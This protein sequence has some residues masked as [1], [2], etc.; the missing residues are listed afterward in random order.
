MDKP[1][2]SW[3]K[4]LTYLL[5]GLINIQPVL[6][7]VVVG[8]TNTTTITAGN[9]VEVVN[10]AA[11]NSKGLSHNQYQQFNVDKSGLILNNS[12]AQLSQSQ[13]G[14]LL[15]N[16]PNLTGQAAS[17]ILNEVT[18]ANRSQLQG[19]TEVFGASA[20]V[21]LANP[22][23]ITCDGCGFINTPR[24]TLS[25]GTP[26]LAN[27]DVS[28][29]DVS[30]G[31][32][33]IEGLGL[34]ASQ[35]T[36]FDIISR[37]AQINAEIHAQNLTIVTGQNHVDYETN[38]A[39]KKATSTSPLPALAIDS[40]SLGGMYAGRIALIAT[41]EGVGVNVGNLAASQEGIHITADGKIVM[42]NTS[43]AQSLTVSTSD[44][45]EMNGNHSAGKQMSLTG[46]AISASNGTLVAGSEMALT[47]GS[48][49]LIHSA[50]EAAQFTA[51][52]DKVSIDET[53][54]VTS[55][56]AS[57]TQ[58]GTLDN[59]GAV[60]VSGDMAIA[61]DT[62]SLTG[63]GNIKAAT[64]TVDVQ[65]LSFETNAEV[66]D[67][68]LTARHALALTAGAQLSASNNISLSGENINQSG[69]LTA[70]Q[71]IA[72]NA[73][74]TLTHNGTTQGKDVSITAQTL[75]QTG[76]LTGN[77]SVVINS[78]AVVLDGDTTAGQRLVVNA[79]TLT[80]RGKVQSG[81]TVT[82][83][84]DTS[85]NT[86]AGSALL[87]GGD[88]KL[89]GS[90]VELAGTTQSAGS[91]IIDAQSSVLDGAISAKKAVTISGKTLTQSGVLVSGDSLTL[92][93]TESITLD[94]TVEAATDITATTQ[95]FS[96]SLTLVSGG[97]I[98]V[99][100]NDTTIEG[101]TSSGGDLTITS[102]TLNQ[103]G[104]TLAQSDMTLITDNS[105]L[106]GSVESKKTLAI[107]ANNRLTTASGTKLTSGDAITINAGTF[108]HQ[109]HLTSQ[110]NTQLTTQ[111]LTNQGELTSNQNLSLAT[112]TLN[113]QGKLSANG[114]M[115]LT[116][117]GAL[118]MSKNLSSGGDL[119]ITAHS[120]NNRA[121]INSAKHTKVTLTGGLTNQSRG[122]I[123]GDTTQIIANSIS[124]SGTLQALNLLSIATAS[125]TNPGALIALGDLIATVSGTATNTDT[126]LIYAGNNGAIYANALNNYGE[127]LTQNNLTI[128]RNAA[129]Q[130]SNSLLNSSASIESLAGDISIYA[131]TV[132]NKVTTLITNPTSNLDI[133]SSFS[134][135]FE[136]NNTSYEPEYKQ[137]S[138]VVETRGGDSR[139]HVYYSTLESSDHFTVKV[140]EEGATIKRGSANTRLNAGKRLFINAVNVINDASLMSGSSILI[141]ALSLNNISYALD[142]YTTYYDYELPA[143]ENNYRRG[144][145]RGTIFNRVGSRRVKTGVSGTLDSSITATGNILLNVVNE[146]DN[147]TI[148]RY[149]SR[150]TPL[151]SSKST[152]TTQSADVTGPNSV[153]LVD[154]SSID[155]LNITLSRFNDVPFPEFRLPSSPNGLF[156]YSK[157]PASGY[158]IETNPLLTNLG[159]YLGSDYFLGN[160]GFDPEKEITFLGDAF[161]DTRVV[162]QAIFEQTGKRYLNESVGNDFGQMQQLMDAAASQKSGLNLE[163][164][165]ALSPEQVANLSQDILWYE[166]IEVNGQTV[167]APKLYLAQLT[168]D[169]IS[170]G[171]VI[172]GRDIDIKAGEINNSGAM[173]ADNT[174]SLKSDSSIH[175]DTG[176]LSGGGDVALVA[177]G[178][179]ENVSGVITGDNVSLDSTNGSVINR[180]LVQINEYNQND[181]TTDMGQTSEIA[182]TG[183]LSINAGKNILN[184]G[185]RLSAKGDTSLT[186]GEDIRFS[187]IE[188]K[189][190]KQQYVNWSTV[191]TLEVKHQG[192]QLISQG[193]ISL[194][195][196]K[197]I[198]LTSAT[199]SAKSDLDVS[200]GGDI[201]IDTALNENYQRTDKRGYTDINR[202][203]THQGSTLSGNNVALTSNKNI[204]L[205]GSS[206]EAKQ[207][208]GVSA[209]GDVSIVAVNDS[210]YH[211]TKT[212]KKKSFGRSKTIIH[213][214]LNETVKG[215]AI[216]AGE[217]ISITAQALGAIQTAGGD[218]DIQV[219]GSSLNADGNVALNADG[220]IVLAAQQYKEYERN[221]TIKK[222]FG[223]LS[224]QDKG[225]IDDATLLNSS[226]ALSGRDININAGRDIAALASE[227]VADGNVNL[228][229]I[230]EVL[231]SAGEVLKQSQ[232]WN[233]KTSFLSGG[234]LF[235]MESQR[236]GLE[237]KT[238]QSSVVQSGGDLT[239]DAGNIKVVG[240]D[241]ASGNNATLL[242]DT[243]DIEFLAATETQKS[244]EKNEK[245]SI[246][247]DGITKMLTSNPSDIVKIEDG[248]IKISMEK[249]QYDKVD[250]DRRATKKKGSE[251]MA[252]RGITAD[253]QAD[254]FIE[255]S[256]LL[257]GQNSEGEGDIRLTA[258]DNIII[259]EAKESSSSKTEEVHAKAE[260]S[261]VVQHQAVEVAKA[262]KGL[263]ESTENLKQAKKDYSTYKKQ[264]DSL[265][266]S[267]A[268]L[269]QEY[270]DKEPGVQFADVE[271]FRDLV[272]DV[273]SDDSWY[274]AGIVLAVED[275]ASKTLLVYQQVA[276]GVAS[277]SAFGWGFNAGLELDLVASK[278][279]SQTQA[280]GSLASKLSGQNITLDAGN[281]QGNQVLVQG[282]QLDAKETLTIDANEVNLLA[283]TETQSNKSSNDTVSGTVSVTF[284]GATGGANVN[285]GYSKNR[286]GS[287]ATTHTNSQ[288]AGKN[289][290]ISSTENTNI[291]GANVEATENLTLTVGQDLNVASVQDRFK[292]DSKSMG[293][294][295][296][297]SLSAV[298][299][300]KNGV[301]KG[302]SGEE[303]G[304]LTGV[305][306]GM[307][308][309]SNRTSSKQTVLTTLTSGNNA[310]ITV[311]NNTDIKG[312]LVATVDKEGK[313]L[314]NLNLST[315]TFSYADLTNTDYS[316]NRSAGLNTGVAVNGDSDKGADGKGPV[317]IGELEQSK[318]M[319]DAT[320]NSTSLQYVNASGYNK[321]KTLA[322]VGQG[323]VTITDSENSHDTTA[324]N[325]D[326]EHTEKDLFTVDRK[327]GDFDV[328]VDHR[329][330]SEDGHKAIAKDIETTHEAGED[331]YRA[332]DS[333]VSS[334]DMDLFDFGKSVSDNRKLTELKNDLLSSQEGLDLLKDLKSTEADKV[335]AAQAEISKKAQ[336]K[337]GLTPEQVNFYD[338]DKTTSVAMQDN[339][340]R[341]VHGG[342]VTDDDHE[343][344]GEVNVDVSD[345]TTKTE[346]LNTL[347]HETYESITE[348]TTGEQTAAQEDLAKS[349]GN[350]LEDRVNQAAGGDLDKTVDK[351]WN[352]SLV[353]SSTAQLGTERVN[354]VGDANVDY[355][356]TQTEA[357]RREELRSFIESCKDASCRN[358]SEFKSK[359]EELGSI[360]KKDDQRD[361][362]FKK[363][364]YSGGGDECNSESAKVVAAHDTWDK[365]T[366]VK[367]SA[368]SSEFTTLESQ[369]A[370]AKSQP[371]E[372]AAGSALA[373]MPTDILIGAIS[374]VPEMVDLATTASAAIQGD[375]GAQ[376]QLKAMYESA[377]ET[378]SDPN[379]AADK[380][381]ADIQA[382]EANGEISPHEAKKQISK[383]YISVAA[384]ATGSAYGIAKIGGSS[385]K[386]E[387]AY[388][389]TNGS[390]IAQNII[391]G[392]NP[393]FLNPDSR[394]GKA[395]YIGDTAQ[396]VMSELAHYGADTTHAIRYTI[397]LNKAKVLD[398]TNPNVASKWG[399]SGGPIN[400]KTKSLGD[401]AIEKGFDVIKFN[402][403]RSGGVNHAVLDNF[404]NV[405]KP[406]LVVPTNP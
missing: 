248:K 262:I 271:E 228:T 176:T 6:A 250:T 38:V 226:Y 370:N 87:S 203:L 127:I 73:S 121:E 63:A 172:A 287:D 178:D 318:P 126:G 40:S 162:T 157:G 202:L 296:G 290:I 163:L 47:A 206:I 242:A 58:L 329:L 395:F 194:K 42:G 399:Y 214:S 394:F 134:G 286:D 187:T 34:D 125:L 404:N 113:H 111:S 153:R 166:Q 244:Y 281:A 20:N 282:A 90:I 62:L 402:S 46:E 401:L 396:T 388:H 100:A 339:D 171:A 223:G 49:E 18:G 124:N 253:S 78:D 143:K 251:L 333:Y 322:T 212:K 123:S 117:N 155:Q 314:G 376:Q 120:L 174:L 367:D 266:K 138:E 327:Q 57:L 95:D 25:T 133:T 216:T 372:L 190:H 81:D 406:E 99:T 64:L 328:T 151:G 13:L 256:Q 227:V 128:A 22:Y 313:D 149:A 331:I 29:F 28:G 17:V 145:Y 210:N 106:T 365:D 175:N 345:A 274:Q 80:I 305:N 79:D 4:T 277:A 393:D 188:N 31:S 179:I 302:Y 129:N 45:I 311:A 109:G 307:H 308:T 276:A 102:A 27:G 93:Q 159:N 169:N 54:R 352:S 374:A 1:I 264:L 292:S 222:G 198:A 211:Y 342:V 140:K 312:A 23:G 5:C 371:W 284:F 239:I 289:I 357:Q 101:V 332:A 364:C 180:T 141:N 347:G 377:V 337:Y 221:Q 317:P 325:R 201:T 92:T 249:A 321:S 2:S 39:T 303:A 14:G 300:G 215:S 137:R 299:S 220:D 383:F 285:L 254:I 72:L 77:Q 61:G 52:A 268:L 229:A 56:S 114:D 375:E 241:I 381:I 83:S 247:F 82:L 349:F 107:T 319:V 351:N 359:Q 283:S 158:L 44:N 131:D 278:S 362:D 293:V 96:S 156:I 199:V 191:D 323:T 231:I 217:D 294:N 258:K 298:D 257:A 366:A 397:N 259:K 8:G 51:Q 66:Q 55:Q 288:L 118:V 379:G 309:S 74:K 108:T 269:E 21:I 12:T 189:T 3:R 245:L 237:T 353:N 230:D 7:N 150:V 97:D 119:S 213:E 144:S 164:G 360:I 19:Y 148:K 142:A 391:D 385:K 348:N 232:E 24:V 291:V 88:M 154:V 105:N 173:L 208:V 389:A 192:S 37:T 130:K 207:S 252:K 392:I 30:E 279:E 193:K 112:D 86:M 160:V 301:L 403:E 358:T 304:K 273:K 89:D 267:L 98:T 33:T 177:K 68:T 234:N 69:T 53:S 346:L 405:L 59:Q 115:A 197:D 400:D 182:A 382:K 260:A 186:A 26:E 48:V 32:V 335:L 315:N 340:V 235:E 116:V 386:I 91:L 103:S 330:L 398:L 35:Q 67:A 355:Y 219:V 378:M 94:G 387:N 390:H 344:H 306:A 240:S 16:N 9:G 195:A 41:E 84:G 275:V 243:G 15:Q 50:A 11:P 270:V 297:F 261:I 85:L 10:I 205:S 350:Q 75:N 218:S 369:N 135:S 196:G 36:Y 380:Y 238:A 368:I 373:E 110:G 170:Y 104:E 354:K 236:E 233:E 70:N 316:Q 320:Y 136:S 272:S 295:G 324:L 310:S 225:S 181:A 361:L 65:A 71:T 185:A 146:V 60:A 139:H 76:Q 255:G 384:A 263:K 200:A 204:T 343:L 168:R 43:S 224:S 280:T 147:R 167:L 183:N 246:S 209:K 122:V 184:E 265:Q 326:T 338:A 165:I 152:K 334:D 341:D 132:T 356:L 161:Y 336:E 363:A